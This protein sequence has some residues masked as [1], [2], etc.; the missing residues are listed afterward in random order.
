MIQ[1][2]KDKKRLFQ[3]SICNHVIPRNE[4]INFYFQI[5]YSEK[6]FRAQGESSS[7]I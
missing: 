3:S 4:H 2:K 6:K 7:L 5:F 1:T